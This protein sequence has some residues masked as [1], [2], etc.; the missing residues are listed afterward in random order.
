MRRNTPSRWPVPLAGLRGATWADAPREIGAGI[1]LAAL[2]IPLNIGYAQVA[3]LP[4]TAGL[5]AAIIPLALFALLTSSRHLITSPDAS[6]AALISSALVAISISDKT[7][8]PDY[9][10]AMAL[11]AGGLFFLFWF[12]RLAFLAN[13]LSRPVM[14]GFVSGLGLEVFIKQII[15]IIGAPHLEEPGSIAA[16]MQE[17]ITQTIQTTGFF[18]ELGELV[19]MVPDANLWSVAIGLGALFLV[20]GLKR[21]APKVPGALVALVAL[22]FLVAVLKLDQKG[23]SVL[24]EIPSGLPKFGFPDLPLAAYATALP[25]AIA[26]VAITLCEGLLLTRKYSRKYGYKADGDQVLF[27][28][29][30]ANVASAM[31]GSILTTA[32]PSRSAAMDAAGQRSQLPSL[33]AAGAITLIMLF[34]SDMLAYL[35][36]AALAGI[37]ANAVINLIAVSEFRDLWRMRR[38]EFWIA[39]T[40]FLS[41]LVLGPMQAVIIATLLS[42][43]DVVS[44]ASKPD[45]WLLEE[46]ADGSH[47]EPAQPGKADV[48]APLVVYRFGASLYFANA[49]AF[50]EDVETIIEARQ[51]P[52]KWVVFDTEAITDVDT[53]GAETLHLVFD[54]LHA[55]GTIIALSRTNPPLIRQLDHYG[56]LKDIDATRIFATNRQALAAFRQATA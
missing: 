8:V 49:N 35:P 46:T 38:V 37:V 25:G 43:I 2:I 12:F 16:G 9:V 1:T 47:L 4:P 13:F 42:I 56:L 5:Y 18:F 26:I 17:A 36:N 50:L 41:V 52:A 24:G 6:L 19:R 39:A 45:T 23:V 14:A 11:V 53:T 54:M 3:G 21:Y 20:R 30:V 29:G 55:Q 31:T 34:F 28:F 32:S 33:V 40:C 51:S 27:A 10:L 15:K 7:M 48:T 44:R 22:T